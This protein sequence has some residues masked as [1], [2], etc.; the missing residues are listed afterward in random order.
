LLWVWDANIVKSW[1]VFSSQGKDS[2]LTSNGHVIIN[3]GDTGISSLFE[4]S[5]RREPHS[6]YDKLDFATNFRSIKDTEHSSA[7]LGSALK[8]S[9]FTSFLLIIIASLLIWKAIDNRQRGSVQT[10][11]VG[12][13]GSQYPK[14]AL[15]DKYAKATSNF[16]KN[17]GTLP[18]FRSVH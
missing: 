16:R 2:L 5:P 3:D 7:V 18:R 13:C 4:I 15:F 11:G 10:Y 14:G 8:T 12:R 6:S 9:T 1:K 17:R